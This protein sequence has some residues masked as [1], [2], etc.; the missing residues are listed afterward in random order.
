[1]APGASEE[2]TLKVSA[3]DNVEGMLD[4]LVG[5]TSILGGQ[6]EV[7]YTTIV[8]TKTAPP[9]S[10]DPDPQA[11]DPD[12]IVKTEPKAGSPGV[13]VAAVIGA[14]LVALF[15]VGRRR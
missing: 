3:A 1:L 6:D 12:P 10:N 7:S 2:F 9:A 8:K 11:S 15:L 4:T 14:T 13:A 5:A